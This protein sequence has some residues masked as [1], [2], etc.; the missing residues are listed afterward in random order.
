M[1]KTP[2]AKA[3]KW[4]LSQSTYYDGFHYAI[5]QQ[6]ERSGDMDP[7]VCIQNMPSAASAR[8]VARL[9]CQALNGPKPAPRKALAAATEAIDAGQKLMEE[10]KRLAAENAELI[11]RVEDL[12]FEVHKLSCN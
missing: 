12:K 11:E 9:I 4:V 7:N 10:N 2:K 6:P 8:R 3:L 1:S 5:I